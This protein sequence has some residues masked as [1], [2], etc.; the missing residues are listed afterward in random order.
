MCKK[1]CAASS[2]VVSS[3]TSQRPLPP[4]SEYFWAT[5]TIRTAPTAFPAATTPMFAVASIAENS[6]PSDMAIGRRNIFATECSK[7]S[8][9][10]VMMGNQRAAILPGAVGEAAA[11]TTAKLTS[12]LAP[13][14]LQNATPAGRAALAVAACA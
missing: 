11:W 3:Q 7:L 14:P 6:A 13:T 9:M 8:A 5:P 4:K 2:R 1:I 12:Q 10:K